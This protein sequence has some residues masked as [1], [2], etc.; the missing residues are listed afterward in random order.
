M[1]FFGPLGKITKA[2]SLNG[3]SG[4]QTQVTNRKG[5]RDAGSGAKC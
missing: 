3:K 1:F 2:E 5:S 4:C